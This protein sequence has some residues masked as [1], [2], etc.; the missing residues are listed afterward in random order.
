[1][2]KNSSRTVLGTVG[3]ILAMLTAAVVSGY[4][5]DKGK[6]SKK[7]SGASRDKGKDSKKDSGASAGK[8]KVRGKV[9]VGDK[10]VKFGVVTFINA[11]ES[12]KFGAGAIE[13]DGS[14]TITNPLE[15]GKYVVTVVSP[16]PR[17]ADPGFDP[18]VRSKEKRNKK[19]QKV[20]AMEKEFKWKKENY[21]A[22]PEDYSDPTKKKIVLEV[23]PGDN[24]VDIHIKE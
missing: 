8:A 7:D 16:K 13:K 18:R 5:G 24:I 2:N 17:R 1:M 14:Y 23:K 12:S 21:V 10:T 4:T 6:N 20:K 19:S 9:K 22:I 3:L 11:I 15:P